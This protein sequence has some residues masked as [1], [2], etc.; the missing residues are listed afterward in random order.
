MESS[1]LC[2]EEQ[3]FKVNLIGSKL[4]SYAKLELLS[5]GAEEATF[6]QQNIPRSNKITEQTE[7]V[8]K[9]RRGIATN[10][11]AKPN[12]ERDWSTIWNALTFVLV[13][14]DNKKGAKVYSLQYK[15]KLKLQTD[16]KFPYSFK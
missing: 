8:R 15:M 13:L 14:F 10:T 11:R 7:N 2:Y 1:T 4:D 16:F 9:W 3:E 5:R 6:E 12:V